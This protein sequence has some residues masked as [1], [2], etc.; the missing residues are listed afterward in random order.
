[1]EIGGKDGWHLKDFSTMV[2]PLRDVS[3]GAF[4]YSLCYCTK[5]FYTERVSK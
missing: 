4:A 5:P 1:M 3:R 2:V